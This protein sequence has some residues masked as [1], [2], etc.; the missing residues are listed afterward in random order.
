MSRFLT[1][2][3]DANA[4]LRAAAEAELRCLRARVDLVVVTAE[5]PGADLLVDGT[6][7]GRSTPERPVVV[8]MGA[9]ELSL[10][11]DGVVS[12]PETV[13]IVGGG[14]QDVQLSL[15]APAAGE[16]SLV[17]PAPSRVPVPMSPP[18]PK[19]PLGR[20]SSPPLLL[21][22]Q[23]D[24]REEPTPHSML[25]RNPEPGG[26]PWFWANPWFWTVVAGAV[27]SAGFV[28]IL[29]HNH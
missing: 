13:T 15:G 28:G 22:S 21:N 12:A 6:N 5:P 11:K 10:E 18:N 24:D 1:E 8:G 16:S 19:R 2:A 3:T 23:L 25:G 9:H 7:V 4:E 17:A 14:S 20:A 26:N 27:L 29:A